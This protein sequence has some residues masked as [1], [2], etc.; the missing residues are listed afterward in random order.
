VNVSLDPMAVGQLHIIAEVK[1]N[2][3]HPMTRYQR[4]VVE[5]K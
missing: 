1:D 3:I 5:V 4:F 2:G